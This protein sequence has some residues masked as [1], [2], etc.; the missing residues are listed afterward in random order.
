MQ[1]R[2]KRSAFLDFNEIASQS[3]QA[4]LRDSDWAKARMR[5]EPLRRGQP[6]CWDRKYN[7]KP[8]GRRSQK[9][10]SARAASSSNKRNSSQVKK[11]PRN[12]SVAEIRAIKQKKL[13]KGGV[14]LAFQAT[15]PIKRSECRQRR[16][17]MTMVMLGA[18]M[19]LEK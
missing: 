12:L 18:K 14:K 5:I 8:K 13:A 3:K 9:S 15:R 4:L 19:R 1:A 17:V 6:H 16:M 7:V 11:M 10:K 2:D